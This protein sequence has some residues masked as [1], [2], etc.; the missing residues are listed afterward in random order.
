VESPTEFI[1]NAPSASRAIL[2][3]LLADFDGLGCSSYVKTIYIGFE[4]KGEMV[5]AAYPFASHVEVAVAL[6]EDH[7]SE[8]LKDA[9]H[10]T[11]R[12]MPVLLSLTSLD[13]VNASEELLA[14]A[15]ERVASGIHEVNLPNDRFKERARRPWQAQ[16]TP[17]TN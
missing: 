8:L 16:V 3:R 15:F 14:E 9:T 6:P 5:A 4:F 2:S 10:L 1:S 7:P 11:W 17:D 12:T 13:D